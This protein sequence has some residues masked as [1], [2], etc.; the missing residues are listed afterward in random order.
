MVTMAPA[1]APIPAARPMTLVPTSYAEIAL[2]LVLAVGAALFF[3]TG[4]AL[5]RYRRTGLFPGE[6]QEAAH[7][8]AAVDAPTGHPGEDADPDRAS[9]GENG[10]G[11]RGTT[12]ARV[13]TAL[14]KCGL[15]AVLM[16]WALGTIIAQRGA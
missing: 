12:Q 9:A 14:V 4:A 3:G 8:D 1:A 2:F 13:R 15:G 10:A 16:V 7:G 5:L 6:D 11:G